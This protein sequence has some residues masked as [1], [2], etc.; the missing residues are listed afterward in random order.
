MSED[1]GIPDAIDYAFSTEGRV[2]GFDDLFRGRQIIWRDE[3]PLF[4]II[5]GPEGSG[6][7]TLAL[8][9]A[10]LG[11]VTQG[12]QS[13]ARKKPSAR[14][15]LYYITDPVAVPR[16]EKKYGDFR[17]DR[18]TNPPHPATPHPVTLMPWGDRPRLAIRGTTLFLRQYRAGTSITEVA[19]QVKADIE[20]ITGGNRGARTRKL[21]DEVTV[22][23]DGIAALDPCGAENDAPSISSGK[24]TLSQLWA[25]VL[26]PGKLGQKGSIPLVVIL[27]DESERSNTD[28]VYRN[29]NP[30]LANVYI[31]LWQGGRSDMDKEN[32]YCERYLQIV[33]AAN[34]PHIRGPQ[35]FRIQAHSGVE[36]HP[37]LAAYHGLLRQKH[38]ELAQ[39]TTEKPS[40]DRYTCFGHDDIDKIIYKD[41]ETLSAEET[42][43]LGSCNLLIG[44]AG[45]YKTPLALHFA[46]KNILKEREKIGPE[47]TGQHK[48]IF[49]SF[50]N[51]VETVSDFL[52]SM[53]MIKEDS[54]KPSWLFEPEFPDQDCYEDIDPDRHQLV[55][56]QMRSWFTPPEVFMSTILRL[57]DALD[58][59]PGRCRI[60]FDAISDLHMSYPR[61]TGKRGFLAVLANALRVHGMTSLFVFN[62]SKVES[63]EDKV[64]VSLAD[65]IFHM[66]KRSVAGKSSTILHIERLGNRFSGY[67]GVMYVRRQPGTK[68]SRER[69]IVEES[70]EAYHLDQ[71]QQLVPASIK[72][73]VNKRARTHGIFNEA[74]CQAHGLS[75]DQLDER[76]AIQRGEA[77]QHNLQNLLVNEDKSVVMAVDEDCL[78]PENMKHFVDLSQWREELKIE[79]K[80]NAPD[81]FCNIEACMLDG[82]PH[83]LPSLLDST[84]LTCNLK[85]LNELSSAETVDLRILEDIIREAQGRLQNAKVH[86]GPKTA[87]L[88]KTLPAIPWQLL[89]DAASEF[90]ACVNKRPY[91]FLGFAESEELEALVVAF[92][93]ALHN[94]GVVK[95]DEELEVSRESDGQNG[96][97]ESAVREQDREVI[98]KITGILE[99][100]SRIYLDDSSQPCR[101]KPT[102]DNCLFYYSWHSLLYS[103]SG[104]YLIPVKVVSIKERWSK[105]RRRYLASG[106]KPARITETMLDPKRGLHFVRGGYYWGIL[107]NG[108]AG[109]KARNVLQYASNDTMNLFRIKTRVG[110]PPRE[111][112]YLNTGELSIFNLLLMKSVFEKSWS[113]TEYQNYHQMASYIRVFLAEFLEYLRRRGSALSEKEGQRELRRWLMRFLE[114]LVDR[115]RQENHRVRA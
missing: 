51:H 69:I 6:K 55:I 98:R 101:D 30:Y 41:F 13:G 28:A 18:F 21:I 104:K 99:D 35:I 109:E 14:C 37:N 75:D 22:V 113:R 20:R 5:W 103:S 67:K 93:D 38:A 83:V 77:Y 65:N 60:V 3:K 15:V 64:I 46:T 115:I 4:M 89:R 63:A 43:P 24:E 57:I 48:A 58:V 39:P 86:I 80:T 95:N 62:E 23:I 94:L 44:E 8:E 9:L 17:L 52:R 56:Q 87:G 79:E 19:R 61:L 66:Y 88:E 110:M 26:I 16:I 59:K 85:I 96:T 100:A 84:V 11:Q 34:C 76:L 92:L 106:A 81:A 45:T 10:S 107:D 108:L 1:G 40:T 2:G 74:I 27:V 68:T 53:Q 36:V 112:F 71:Y 111:K 12:F 78:R 91:R 31:R 7:S 70:L 29:R 50:Y 114:A 73:Y 47:E 32:G 25:R 102:S 97:S 33:K 49:I 105:V 42:I 90:H 54:A 72:L 82:T